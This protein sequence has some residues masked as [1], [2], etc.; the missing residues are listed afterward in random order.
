MAHR[1]SGFVTLSALLIACGEAPPPPA[2]AP[3]AAPPTPS[4]SESAAPAVEAPVA[5]EAKSAPVKPVAAEDTTLK[6]TQK[7]RDILTG[8]GTMFMLQF[9][10]SDP[11]KTAPDKC[12]GEGDDAKKAACVQKIREKLQADAMK[13]RKDAGG[14]WYWHSM[15]KKGE[16]YLF[17]HK[18]PFEFGEE[19]DR[20]IV[21][22]TRGA[23]IGI[24]PW[25]VV[26][27]EVKIEVVNDYTITLM[28]PQ[29][30]KLVF[31]AKIGME[32]Q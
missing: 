18:V 32:G 17:S 6:P 2:A 10:A 27:K 1:W 28:D 19:T 3:T 13:F 7:P 16:Q 5:P 15:L 22:K 4:A 26:P 21:L 23:D 25:G 20:S 31:E 30:G 14:K 12:K 11:G 24:S 8:G 29:A 9:E